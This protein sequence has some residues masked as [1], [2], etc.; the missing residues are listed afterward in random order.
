M[1]KV[2]YNLGRRIAY[3]E[4]YAG[5]ISDYFLQTFNNE[6]TYQSTKAIP[7]Q[8]HKNL[9]FLL[10]VSNEENKCFSQTQLLQPLIT[11]LKCSEIIYLKIKAV[12][13]KQSGLFFLHNLWIRCLKINQ[14]LKLTQWSSDS[15]ICPRCSFQY[16]FSAC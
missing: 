13:T 15:P 14:N 8:E 2:Q 16:P 1:G 5:K 12:M 3:S 10:Q 7:V 6:M 4:H 9:L 11:V